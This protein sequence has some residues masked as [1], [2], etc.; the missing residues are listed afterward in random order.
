MKEIVPRERLQIVSKEKLQSIIE[1][2]ILN[3]TI[4]DLKS[5]HDNLQTASNSQSFK[6]TI[7]NDCN[8]FTEDI[9]N[10]DI[11]IVNI[12]EKIQISEVNFLNI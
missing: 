7:T 2:S 3:R 9:R 10:S 4:E 5:P 8:D 12:D 11:D 1:Q 6:T